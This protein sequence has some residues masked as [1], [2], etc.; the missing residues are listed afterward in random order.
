VTSEYSEP[1]DEYFYALNN[2][3]LLWYH[4]LEQLNNNRKHDAVDGD[5]PE[6]EDQLILLL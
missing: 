2:L 1:C 5:E 6:R 3:E 4:A